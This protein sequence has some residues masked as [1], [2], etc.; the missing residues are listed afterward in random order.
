M[1]NSPL[2]L[3]F[4]RDV[5]FSQIVLNAQM[6]TFQV[7]ACSSAGTISPEG[8]GSGVIDRHSSQSTT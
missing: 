2:L 8:I 3:H 5:A 1:I 6:Y 4:I 7:Y